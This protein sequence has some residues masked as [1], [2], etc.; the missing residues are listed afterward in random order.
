[1]PTQEQQSGQSV[2]PFNSDQNYRGRLAAIVLALLADTGKN[3][4]LRTEIDAL[5]RCEAYAHESKTHGPADTTL[6]VE[7][8]AR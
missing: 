4:A 3:V 5:L 1:M 2:I 6:T 7:L 8:A